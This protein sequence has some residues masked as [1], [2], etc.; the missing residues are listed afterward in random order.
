MKAGL[1]RRL[2]E[3]GQPERA[4]REIGEVERL[5]RRTLADVRAAVSGQRDIRLANEL[6]TAREML[7]AAGIAADLPPSVDIVDPTLS[8]LFGWVVREG[9]TNVVRHSRATKCT[10][11][12][13][14]GAVE[15]TDD[16][17]GASPNPGP[18][19]GLTGL[20]ER[21]ASAGGTLTAGPAARGFRLR[22]EVPVVA[23]A[24]EPETAAPTIST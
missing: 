18:G 4:L 6:A 13:E 10:V 14:P 17:L 22:V 2:A 11:T 19:S 9:I 16:G 3:R 24:G 8:E 1:A 23:P 20:G 5:S 7:R 12:L 21:V 15:I